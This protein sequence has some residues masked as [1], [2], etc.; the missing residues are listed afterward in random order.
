MP[1][2]EKLDS[3]PPETLMSDSMKSLDDSESVNVS[4][5][6]SPAFKEETSELMAIVGLM[7]SIE[8]VTVLF[9][10]EPSLLKLPTASENL[11]DAIEITPFVVLSAVGVK[12]AV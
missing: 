5:A 6:V 3:E 1:E 11:V 7:V 10:S 2:P 8:S 4:A 12:V 9:E